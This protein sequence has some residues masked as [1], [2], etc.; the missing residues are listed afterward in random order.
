M[1]R[2]VFLPIPSDPADKLRKDKGAAI[3]GHNSSG[4]VFCHDIGEW[5]KLKPLS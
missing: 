4:G 5:P 2:G 1:C 3:D